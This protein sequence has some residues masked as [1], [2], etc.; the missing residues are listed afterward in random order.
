MLVTPLPTWY[1]EDLIEEKRLDES[2]SRDF[3]ACLSGPFYHLFFRALTKY[4][5]PLKLAEEQ[6][7]IALDILFSLLGLGTTQ[8][9]K[10]VEEKH[11]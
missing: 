7:P 9:R 11:T 6:S 2:A 10:H 3:L 1:T 4:R 8:Y 5:L